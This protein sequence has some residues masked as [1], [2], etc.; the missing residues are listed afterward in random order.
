[1]TVV[2]NTIMFRWLQVLSREIIFFYFKHLIY[3]LNIFLLFKN[4]RHLAL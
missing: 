1:M 4:S 2:A 3:I